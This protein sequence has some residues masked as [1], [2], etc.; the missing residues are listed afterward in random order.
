GRDEEGYDARVLRVANVV[1][2]HARVEVR[3]AG[4]IGIGFP[5]SL[6]VRRVVRAETPALVAEGLVRRLARRGRNGQSRNRL[7]RGRIAHVDDPR[8]NIRLVAVGVQRFRIADDEAAVEARHVDR[9]ERDHRAAR[10]LVIGREAAYDL[11]V[12]NIREVVDQ[13]AERTVGAVAELAAVLHFLRDVHRTV[14]AGEG[15]LVAVFAPGLVLRFLTGALPRHPPHRDLLGV[16]GIGH[17]HDHDPVAVPANRALHVGEAVVGRGV[18]IG[19]VA[20]VVVV[21][22]RSRAGLDP[23]LGVAAVGGELREQGYAGG[24][25]RVPD[26]DSA[27]TLAL[28]GLIDQARVIVLAVGGRRRGRSDRGRCSGDQDPLPEFLVERDLKLRASERAVL[29]EFRH[30]RV[31]DID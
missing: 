26:A 8:W 22:V 5:G 3:V 24:V 19:V 17:V 20:A 4:E 6:D 15:D 13:H 30:P 21:A 31:A 27:Q 25:G 12:A 16:R 2:L 11:R 29:D 10:V 18:E 9:V 23:A 14:Q 28:L 1:T 7:R